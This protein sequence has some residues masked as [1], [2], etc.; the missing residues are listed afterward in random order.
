MMTTRRKSG[1]GN[2]FFSPPSTTP[3]S[4]FDTLTPPFQRWPQDHVV[5]TQRAFSNESR[6]HS[7]P[8]FPSDSV[9][10]GVSASLLS[11]PLVVVPI[12]WGFLIYSFC[13]KKIDSFAT[14]ISE[15]LLA[16]IIYSL[17]KQ[18]I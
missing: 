8:S 11:H 16:R 3:S 2:V 9:D 7:R 12:F 1:G 17:I 5:D 6:N 13:F 4:F 14:R 10:S 18:G 15:L